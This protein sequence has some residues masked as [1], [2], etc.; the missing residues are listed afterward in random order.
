MGERWMMSRRRSVGTGIRW[1]VVGIIWLVGL[2]LPWHAARAQDD[3]DMTPAQRDQL[4]RELADDV[5]I[6]ERQGALLK[7]AVR[8][9]R[10][11]VVHIEASK[12]EEGRRKPVEEAGSGVIVDFGGKFYVLTNRHVVLNAPLSGIELKLADGRE[13]RPTRQWSD[14]GT[15]VAVI[16]VGAGDLVAARLGDSSKLEI[17][18]FVLAVGSPFG[19]SHS[20]TFGIISAKGRHDLELGSRGVEL[21]DFLQTDAAINPGNSGGPLL[22]LRGEV[23]GINTAIASSGGGNEGIGFSIPINMAVNVAR[24]LVETGT[25]SR[26]FLGVLLDAEYNTEA[27]VRLGLP[28]RF[29][30]RIKAVTQ[31]SAAESAML[32]AGDIIMEFDGVRIED[33]DHLVS[34]VSLTPIGQEVALRVFRAGR[35]MVVRVRVQGRTSN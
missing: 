16:A 33:D 17:G 24:Q 22:N 2:A 7:K 32:Q 27:A 4:F 23:V 14:P 28:R 29:G 20:V 34:K 13:I 10:P 21:Q 35:P 9:V 19:L 3:L 12:M 1:A 15:D 5:A 30:A 8:L 18:D 11:T 25:V 31:N 26:A 6:L